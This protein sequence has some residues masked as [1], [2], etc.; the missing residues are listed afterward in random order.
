MTLQ[1]TIDL[2]IVTCWCG[3]PHAIPRSLNRQQEINGQTCYCPLGH[4]YVSSGQS[5]NAKLRQQLTAAQDATARAEADAR[6]WRERKQDE[7]RAHRATKG[8]LT[9]TRKR[10]ANGVCPCCHR[11][12]VNVQ[13][14][15]ATQHPDF[16]ETPTE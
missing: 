2:V 11:S 5:Q 9:K 14:H 7:E 13:R 1:A 4:A 10:I 15:M 8:V 3:M 16:A 12:F 6:W